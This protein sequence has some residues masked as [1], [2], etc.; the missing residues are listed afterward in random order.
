MKL[1]SRSSFFSLLAIAVVVTLPSTALAQLS[2]LPLKSGLWET[3]VSVKAEATN[4]DVVNK[5]C[6]TAG[7]TVGD[8]LTAL[9]KGSGAQCSVNNKVQS[10]HGFSY[11]TVCTGPGMNSKGHTDIQLAGAESFSG[12]SH[13]T[14]AGNYSG[15]QINMAVDKTFSA[16]F[17]GSDCGDVK[18]M[19]AP[20]K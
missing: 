14:V 11:D 12:T 19:V 16:K 10:S 17:L 3:H 2:D 8:Y 9:N 5:S 20:R 4:N 1:W 15:K 13:T 7:T 18:P 6:F